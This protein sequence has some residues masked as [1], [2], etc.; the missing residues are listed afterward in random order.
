MNI[1]I[2]RS[3]IFTLLLIAST[4]FSCSKKVSDDSY[5]EKGFSL[6]KVDSFKVNHEN[7]IRI[8]DFEEDKGVFLGYDVIREEFLLLDKAGEISENIKRV[9]EG[10]DEYKSNIIAASFDRDKSGYY[11]LSSQEF[12]HYN[13][14]W[15]VIDRTIFSSYYTVNLYTGPRT[16]VP[17][18]TKE[19]D[20][21]IQFF[22]SFFPN[23]GVH[24][25]DPKENLREKKLIEYYD[26]NS[27]EINWALN[28]DLDF[29][30]QAELEQQYLSPIQFF[31]LDQNENLLYLTFRNS[32]LLGIYDLNDDF[33]LLRKIELN[34]ASFLKTNQARNVS[35]SKLG[36]GHLLLL[37]YTGKSEGDIQIETEKN[38][39]YLAYQDPSSY[40]LMI[41]DIEGEKTTEIPFPKDMEPHSE[42]LTIGKASILFR[43]QESVEVE[44][45]F[46]KYS[47]FELSQ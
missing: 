10:P 25:F 36:N 7:R 20:S 46:S 29:F 6:V 19:G 44:Q 40:Q 14:S 5:S 47:V 9:G 15:S 1:Q 37:Y 42:I 33:K 24:R 2:N 4:V 27:N 35:L 31:H 30:G 12:I 43:N 41:I 13:E 39:S 16:N 32:N 21:G 11:L 23:I 26:T 17:Y 22:C 34:H 8:L 45:D 3:L 18:F 38:P 28:L